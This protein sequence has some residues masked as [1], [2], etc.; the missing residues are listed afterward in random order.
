M[1]FAVGATLARDTITAQY[2]NL[3]ARRERMVTR[4]AEQRGIAKGG[5]VVMS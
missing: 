2:V 4:S 3:A 5:Q 1:R